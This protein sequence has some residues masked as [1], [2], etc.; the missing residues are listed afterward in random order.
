[1]R[2]GMPLTFAEVADTSAGWRQVAG[3]VEAAVRSLADGG[4]MC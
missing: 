3:Q 2:I 4:A 1:V